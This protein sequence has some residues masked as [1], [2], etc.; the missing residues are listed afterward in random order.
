MIWLLAL[1]VIPLAFDTYLAVREW[2]RRRFPADRWF[3][4]PKVEAFSTVEDTF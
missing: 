3:G 2:D 1:C 4:N